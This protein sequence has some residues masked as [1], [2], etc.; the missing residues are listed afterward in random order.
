MQVKIKR[1]DTTLPLPVYKTAGSVCFDLPVREGA[2]INPGELAR[3]PLNVVVQTPAGYM[4]MLVPRSSLPA[5]KLGLIYPHGVGVIDQD[6]CGPED[7]IKLQVMNASSLPI[8]I[9]RGEVI[10]QAGFVRMDKAELVEE[11]E[12]A[13]V[14]RGGFGSTDKIVIS[15]KLI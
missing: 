3:L 6:Y 1:I 12:L 14:S 13:A 4:L 7:E 2:V 8:T 5:K 10:A 9:E 15:E 11:Y